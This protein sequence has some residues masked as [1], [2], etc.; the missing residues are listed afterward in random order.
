[1]SQS[2]MDVEM[3]WESED[4]LLKDCSN[5]AIT[6][7][8]TPTNDATRVDDVTTVHALIPITDDANN[9]VA[10][11]DVPTPGHTLLHTSATPDGYMMPLNE[12]KLTPNDVT[13]AKEIPKLM[14]VPIF[15]RRQIYLHRSGTPMMRT[16]YLPRFRPTDLYRVQNRFG[17]TLPVCF[18]CLKIGHV[19]KHCK[20]ENKK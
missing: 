17:N 4:E 15:P 2:P 18:L 9:L 20:T 13:A 11:N 16:N 19:K 7:H 10:P 14:S 8:T 1:M 5:D 3:S 6:V 12:T